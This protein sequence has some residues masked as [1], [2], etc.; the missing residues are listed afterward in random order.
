MEPK[1]TTARLKKAQKI[2][3]QIRCEVE[4]VGV[5]GMGTEVSADLLVTWQDSYV[6]WSIF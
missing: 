1:F 4:A 6:L 5:W 2:L 3:L